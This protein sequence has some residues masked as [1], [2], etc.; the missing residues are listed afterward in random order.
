MCHFGEGGNV[1]DLHARVGGGLQHQQLG[2]PCPQGL[3]NSP[4]TPVPLAWNEVSKQRQ[5]D[6]RHMGARVGCLVWTHA[7]NLDASCIPVGSQS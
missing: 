3:L 4:A 6:S 7:C 1:T 2:V 5:H